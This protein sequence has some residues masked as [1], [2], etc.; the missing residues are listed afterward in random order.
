LEGP[1]GALVL[2]AAA[3]S[4][5]AGLW[6][7]NPLS[8]DE[9]SGGADAGVDVNPAANGDG[10]KDAAGSVTWGA[11]VCDA[12]PHASCLNGSTRRTYAS[13]TCDAGQCE[14]AEIDT[15][16]GAAGCCQDH[17]CVVV[18]PNEPVLGGLTKTGIATTAPQGAF[19]T[20]TDCSTPSA[21]GD[22]APVSL[23]PTSASV[24][25]TT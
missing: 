17:C 3:A 13:G 4:A 15:S 22:C 6:G 25:S 7:F 1:S 10:G 14:Y 8:N 24:A 18:P 23:G 5:C 11:T 9:G 20:T 19:D 21:L 16:C 2:L 12:P